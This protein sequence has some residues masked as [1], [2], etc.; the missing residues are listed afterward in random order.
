MS[1][2]IPAK[3]SDV[4]DPTRW[5]TVSGF[6]D[7][8]DMT[9]HRQVERSADGTVVPRDIITSFTC[10]YNGTEIFRAE[11]GP[12]G[13]ITYTQ[14]TSTTGGVNDE[15]RITPGPLTKIS[16]SARSGTSPSRSCS[17]LTRTAKN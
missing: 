10:R 8:Q 13:A 3:V 9:Y 12:G 2:E 15:P 17:S 11:I 14:V 5:R 1:N 7:F 4:F 16:P 6:D